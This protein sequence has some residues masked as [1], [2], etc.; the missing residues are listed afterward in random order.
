MRG[1]IVDSSGGV[2]GNDLLDIVCDLFPYKYSVVSDANDQA[3]TAFC[4]YLDFDVH[5]FPSGLEIN[6]WKVPD[7]WCVLDATIRHHGSIIYDAK[8]H[9]FAV[10]AISP[11]FVGTLDAADLKKHLYFSSESPGAVPYHWVNLYRPGNRDWAICVTKDFYD[12]IPEGEFEVELRVSEKPGSMKVL[13]FTLP[14]E[15]EETVIVNA[16]NC[17]PFQANDDISGCA[18]GIGVFLSLSRWEKRKFT[19]RLLIAPELIG[20]VHWLNAQS[21][22]AQL[23]VGALLLKSVGNSASLRLQYS[24]TGDSQ[25]D[26]AAASVLASRQLNSLPG[27]FRTVYG[28]DETVFDSPG[29]EIP[30]ISLTRYPFLGYH[31][32]A[33]VPEALS[34]QAL[35]ETLDCVLDIFGAI[36]RNQ[37]LR[38]SGRGLVALSHPRYDLYRAAPAPGLDRTPYDDSQRQWNLLMN[39]LPREL[40]GKQSTIDLAVKYGLPVLDVCDY[41]EEWVVRGLAHVEKR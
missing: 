27:K 25:L 1:P 9:P 7:N 38:F 39:C 37:Y 19:Y 16:H 40:N 28:N 13:D 35:A 4:K 11:G 24:F 22:V 8:S 29:Y 23:F 6:G 33:D 5:E 36:E 30:T 26:R 34:T 41:L 21:D 14:G 10:G 31:T 15:S 3:I 32:D 20:T 2:S 12:Q 17:H 18:V